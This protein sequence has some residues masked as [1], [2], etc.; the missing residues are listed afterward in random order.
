MMTIQQSD[1]MPQPHD[2]PL[3]CKARPDEDPV[4]RKEGLDD[5]PMSHEK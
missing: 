3:T 4:S 5:N 1:Y 2:N